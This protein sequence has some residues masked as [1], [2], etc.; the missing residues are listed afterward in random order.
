ML[1]YIQYNHII[2]NDFNG[3]SLKF[4]HAYAYKSN[5]HTNIYSYC[6]FT[7]RSTFRIIIINK[8]G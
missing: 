2:S 1:L 6:K 4:V 8:C 5:Y 3:I 7:N